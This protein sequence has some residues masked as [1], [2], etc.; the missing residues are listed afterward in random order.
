MVFFIN[1]HYSSPWW[2]IWL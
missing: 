1:T 2:S